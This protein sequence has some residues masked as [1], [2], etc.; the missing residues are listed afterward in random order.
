MVPRHSPELAGETSLERQGMRTLLV[1]TALAIAL[2]VASTA[3]I[4]ALPINASAVGEVVD[5]NSFVS[6][7][8]YYYHR[9]YYY[10]HYYYHPRYYYYH[11][12]YWRRY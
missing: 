12:Y 10:R 3:E 5:G 2:G 9:H 1:A 4:S 8:Y 11:K 6:P 7:A